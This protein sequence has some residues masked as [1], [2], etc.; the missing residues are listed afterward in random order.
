[1]LPAEEITLKFNLTEEYIELNK[2]LKICDLAPSGGV[3]GLFIK[4][5]LVCVDGE[6]ETRKRKK[7][8]AGQTVQFEDETIEVVDE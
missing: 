1:M 8:F 3:A 4:D 5:G 7:I 6:V 2:L